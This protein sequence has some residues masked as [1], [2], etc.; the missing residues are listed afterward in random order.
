[1]WTI[2]SYNYC[3]H[4][5]KWTNAVTPCIVLLHVQFS[6]TLTIIQAKNVGANPFY[7]ILNPTQKKWQ[8]QNYDGRNTATHKSQTNKSHSTIHLSKSLHNPSKITSYFLPLVYTFHP[9]ISYSTFSTNPFPVRRTYP[10][11]VC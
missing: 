11:T 2:N 10:H 1:M 3:T 8:P 4:E 6:D 7:K 5:G 9:F